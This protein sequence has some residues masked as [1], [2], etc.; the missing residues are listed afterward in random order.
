MTT[1]ENSPV[2]ELA[3]MTRRD[4]ASHLRLTRLLFGTADHPVGDSEETPTHTVSMTDEGEEQ[5]GAE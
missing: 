2:L 3:W 1:P 4:S 5:G